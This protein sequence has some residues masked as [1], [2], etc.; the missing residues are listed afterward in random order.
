[1]RTEYTDNKQNNHSDHSAVILSENSSCTLVTLPD[2]FNF[3]NRIKEYYS[4]HT[5]I[6]F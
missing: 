2:L 5:R 3:V 1:M 4:R 6:L